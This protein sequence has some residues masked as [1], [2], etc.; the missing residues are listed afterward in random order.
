MDYP[1]HVYLSVVVTSRN[2]NHGGKIMARM[3]HCFL[4]LSEQAA[5]YRLPIQLLLVD[6]N[7]PADRPPLADMAEF[8]ASHEYFRFD[9]VTVAPDIHARMPLADE[10]PLF[11]YYAKN[12]GIRRA[13]GHFVL[14]TN[15]DVILFEALA[16][17]LAARTLESG[18]IYR[19]D[20]WDTDIEKELATL[21]P[22]ARQ[23]AC[24]RNIV[25][26]NMRYGTVPVPQLAAHVA[27]TSTAELPH[28]L[29]ALERGLSEKLKLERPYKHV[30]PHMVACGDFTLMAREDWFRLRGYAELPIHSWHV[31]SLLMLQGIGGGLRERM[32]PPGCG[33]FHIH[34][35]PGWANQGML[36]GGLDISLEQEGE[37]A[38]LKIVGRDMPLLTM[39]EVDRF[40]LDVVHDPKATVNDR[41]WGLANQDLPMVTRV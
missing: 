27:E 16:E 29:Q 38:L 12:V 26:I 35:A 15:V 17:H 21:A 30:L 36:E 1:Q 39:D 34:H 32:L 25:Q 9:V 5:R 24:M 33:V 23:E 8:G 4:S 22:E 3:R 28:L 31:D 6:W 7:P 18:F 41:D 2:D 11:Q 19:N 40:A 20:R 14:A 37:G 10:I 13:L